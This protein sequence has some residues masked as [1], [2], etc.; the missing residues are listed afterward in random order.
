MVSFPG[1]GCFAPF[2]ARWGGRRGAEV[3]LRDE[4][5]KSGGKLDFW[6][7]PRARPRAGPRG[8]RKIMLF[9]IFLR[10]PTAAEDFP[11]KILGISGISEKSARN[12]DFS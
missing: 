8:P 6:Q 4:E 2:R 5:R 9:S 12:L 3:A 1:G 7:G 11:E 10:N